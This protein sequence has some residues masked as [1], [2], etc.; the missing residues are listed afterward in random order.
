LRHSIRKSVTAQLKLLDSI[1]TAQM[2]QELQSRVLTITKNLSDKMGEK[3][4]V[5][6]SMAVEDMKR[7]DRN[8]QE[9]DSQVGTRF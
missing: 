4:G 1:G 8:G 3:N 9:R 6:A 5:E 7:T 2:E